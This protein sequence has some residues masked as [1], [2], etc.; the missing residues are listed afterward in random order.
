[1]QRKWSMQSSFLASTGVVLLVILVTLLFAIRGIA[2]N[3]AEDSFDR[4]LGAAALS[5]VDTVGFEDGQVTVDIP[6][7]SFTILGTSKLNRVFYKV[8][9]PD[10]T[11]VTGSPLLGLDIKPAHSADLRLSDGTFRGTP[12]RIAAVARFKTSARGELSGWIDV[13]VAETREARDALADQLTFNAAFPAIL[14]ALVA[15]LLVVVAIRRAFA[16]LKAIEANVR[17][18]TPSDVSLISEEVPS[19]VLALVRALNEFISRFSSTLESLKLVTADAAHQLRTPIAALRALSEVAIEEAPEGVIRRRL[20][21]IHANSVHATNLANQ[22][23]SEAT[24][25]HRL[26]SRDWGHFDLCAKVEEVLA[27]IAKEK[28]DEQVARISYARGGPSLLIHGE[29]VSVRELIRNLVENALVH[30]SGPIE[31][32]TQKTGNLA[33]MKICDRGPGIPPELGAK[34]FERFVRGGN[35]GN[36]SGLGLAIARKV[37]AAMGGTIDLRDRDGGGLCVG[38]QLPLAGKPPSLG[39]LAALCAACTIVAATGMTPEPVSA[40]QATS[41]LVVSSPLA[42][43]RIGP[44]LE[45][46]G[47]AV[48]PSQIVYKQVPEY[49]I[50]SDIEISTSDAVA[51]LVIL[52][53]PD[54]AI[55]L[56]ND[57]RAMRYPLA[58][59]S[60]ESA[61]QNWRN[62]VYAVAYDTAAFLFRSSVFGQAA[63]N[64][65]LELARLLEWN[66]ADY[67]GRI[68]LVNIGIDSVGYAFAAQDS[69]RSSLFWRLTTA[70]GAAQARIYDNAAELV[71]ALADGDI[72]I[73]FNVPVSSALPALAADADLRVVIPED[74][75]IAMPWT[76]LIPTN[77]ANPETAKKALEFLVATPGKARFASIL[78]GSLISRPTQSVGLGPE[79]LVF[80]D[81]AKKTRFLDTW[82]QLVTNSSCQ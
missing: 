17:N 27:T 52:P 37:A 78:T 28:P 7:S 19:E 51:D 14:V 54:L 38:V 9:G 77:A 6:Y 53:T 39:A 67:A 41:S 3:A 10:G 30:T 24:V 25:A 42:T 5:I 2:H 47:A 1:M 60:P 71:A 66:C 44:L 49:R 33:M 23:L 65:R 20:Q 68:G 16:P 45:A 21:R 36:G 13:M 55:Q 81:S 8:V 15:F 12:I 34:V 56:V 61:Q 50:V 11:L 18:R 22:L 70:L 57:G 43:E 26:E 74:Y 64:S 62:E 69:L 75:T 4:V 46:M 73:A 59:E 80:L 32:V 40:Q 35:S 29:A 72:D 48:A 63:P 31:I 76:V 79:L 82:F 58:A